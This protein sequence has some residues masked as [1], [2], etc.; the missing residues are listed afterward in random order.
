[1]LSKA[2][3]PLPALSGVTLLAGDDVGREEGEIFQF[4]ISL[5]IEA[6]QVDV[7]TVVGP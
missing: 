4:Q 2:V 6:R 5:V 1:M 3:P 7:V